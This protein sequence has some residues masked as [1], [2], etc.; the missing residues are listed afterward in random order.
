MS[1]NIQ[2]LIEE[3]LA[4][5][6][7]QDTI[8]NSASENRRSGSEI[9]FGNRAKRD[10]TIYGGLSKLF[11]TKTGGPRFSLKNRNAEFARVAHPIQEHKTPETYSWSPLTTME[12]GLT[13]PYLYGTMKTK[14]NVIAAHLGGYNNTTSQQIIACILAV[15]KGPIASF[16]SIS[17]NG[18]APIL[19]PEVSWVD[20]R[21]GWNT[22]PPLSNFNDAYQLIDLENEP[23]SY[24][25]PSEGLEAE[26][27]PT[28]ITV[29][30]TGFD[31]AWI[32][33]SFPSGLYKQME[34]NGD[35]A[36]ESCNVKV[37]IK[38]EGGSYTTVF[39]SQ[40][41][42]NQNRNY[43][44][45]I[46]L[47]TDP[48]GHYFNQLANLSYD[49]EVTKNSPDKTNDG[50]MEV[51]AVGTDGGGGSGYSISDQ[52][53]VFVDDNSTDKFFG[54][55][56]ITTNT[57][58][59][60]QPHGFEIIHEPNE[61]VNVRYKTTAGK[62]PTGLIDDGLYGVVI[63]STTELMFLNISLDASD[64]FKGKLTASQGGVVMVATLSGSAIASFIILKRGTGHKVGDNQ[65]IIPYVSLSGF[66][67]AGG[68]TLNI[69]E[70]DQS[71]NT[72]VIESL[73]VGSRDDFTYNGIALCAMY[74]TATE[75]LNGSLDVSMV[76]KGRLVRVYTAP[77][78]Y[79]LVWSDNPA[80]ICLDVLT[81]PVWTNESYTWDVDHWNYNT[82]TLARNDGI[83]PADID[84]GSF[85]NWAVHCDEIVTA[86]DYYSEAEA[87]LE[88]RC[89]F[90][91]IFD[92]T[93]NLWDA[94]QSIASNA[95]A[96]LL[97][98]SGTSK[99]RVVLNAATTVT[100][101]FTSANIIQDSLEETYTS[102][103][104]R[105]TALQIDFLNRENDWEPETFNVVYLSA[106]VPREDSLSLSGITVPSQAWRRAMLDLY[107]NALTTVEVAFNVGQDALNCE[108]GD[109]VGVQSELPQWGYGGRIVSSSTSTVVLDRQV[110]LASNHDYQLC[111]RS[112]SDVLTTY[113]ILFSNNPA[114]G[115]TD[116]V[117]RTTN[118]L[119]GTFNSVPALYDP[120]A[121]GATIGL[122]KY[123]P[124]R[125]VE[126]TNNGDETFHIV[127]HEYNATVWNMDSDTPPLTT[128]NYSSLNAHPPV[129]FDQLDEIL[130]INSDGTIIDCLDVYFTR[131]SSSLYAKAAIYYK[132]KTGG[133]GVY[134][135][136]WV[137]AG[138]TD[139]EKFRISNVLYSESP[140]HA[141]E[142][143][144]KVAI[145]TIN[146]AGVKGHIKNSP[147]KEV[148]TV[149]KLDPPSTVTNF[150]AVQDDQYVCFSW[151]HI[152]DMDLLGYEIRMGGDHWE[153]AHDI[154][155]TG[156]SKDKWQ[157][158]AW[159]D[160]TYI[161]R[162]KAIDTTKHYSLFDAI[163]V[164]TLVG[165]VNNFFLAYDDI[166]EGAPGTKVN[167]T[168][169]ATPVKRLYLNYT[170]D[171][172][173]SLT[174]SY[175]S[176]AIDCFQAVTQLVQIDVT[177]YVHNRLATDQTYPDRTD[178]SYPNDTDQHVHMDG[179]VTVIEYAIS[180][181]NIT[182][183]A[184]APYT[185]GINAYFRYIKLKVSQTNPSLDSAYSIYSIK[186]LLDVPDVTIRIK[187]LVVPVIDDVHGP[188]YRVRFSD[189]SSKTF[190]TPPYV[191]ATL[192]NIA[193]NI[194]PIIEHETTTS[195]E[196]IVV[197]AASESISGTVDIIAW[198]Y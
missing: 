61:I 165:I 53:D 91:G 127:G 166:L 185:V 131:P 187:N 86:P 68:A 129:T 85:Y 44:Y 51:V 60:A 159:I 197:D 135:D 168:Y 79:M 47:Q 84:I 125:V 180:V 193:Y 72:L 59:F 46:R 76:V 48:Q 39:D 191:G 167:M 13:I 116:P 43:R 10:G 78:E 114:S 73:V 139:T 188:W 30:M 143:W 189:Y 17:I 184:F 117:A 92:S 37:R 32:Y 66:A 161:F 153:E 74:E 8:A 195:F 134:P 82:I 6:Q 90:N 110:E 136:A 177:S 122:M 64:D 104:D 19:L 106:D 148:Q 174:G 192:K 14:G 54:K 154:L 140:I 105:A 21:Y 142:I 3:I 155:V 40:I 118:H 121:F 70:I 198:G 28:I 152:P 151:T 81:Q 15:S 23:V 75:R 107:Y 99:Y 124:F 196:I 112:S 102:M 178:Q 101:I 16:E 11:N 103:I 96:W 123:K 115:F 179:G 163:M 137:Y 160:G 146:T 77:E 164:I 130:I 24:F 149:G 182:W 69:I 36:N 27:L 111:V 95:R 45:Y 173:D 9:P 141:L 150:T 55:A 133:S 113:P 119:K 35:L 56:D 50:S 12:S 176:N 194:H 158:K 33:L 147:W 162:I 29:D 25:T 71:V 65:Q 31:D 132:Q 87:A 20:Y 2:Q 26:R 94:A 186:T 42:N 52:L 190:L 100:Q 88:K 89:T 126:L 109:V 170:G 181:D 156:L 1:K 4:A 172:L 57:I 128:P 97:P 145:V 22:Q 108:V 38:P 67:S 18:E 157:W 183:T 63:K 138:T 34:S 169:E 41:T 93:T 58:T 98:P 171:V 80:W 49:I 83:D 120:Y 144:Y 175:A 62:A 7:S 5:N